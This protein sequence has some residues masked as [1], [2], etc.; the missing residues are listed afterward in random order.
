M[1]TGLNGFYKG[2]KITERDFIALYFKA[3]KKYQ[4]LL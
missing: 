4:S 3:F 1:E 2:N